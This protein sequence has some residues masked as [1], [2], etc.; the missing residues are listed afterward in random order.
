MV[1]GKQDDNQPHQNCS[2]AYLHFLGGNAPTPQISLGP[3]P[4]QVVR[5]AKLLGVTVYDQLTWKLHVTATMRSAAYTLYMLR[6]LKSLGT[7]A[8]E[9]KGIYI[10][11]ILP[12]L[13]YASPVWSTSLTCTKKQ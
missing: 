11:F 5:S 4:L 3:H 7:P 12:K 10:T 2:N 13:T 6:R 9:L 8:D 1:G